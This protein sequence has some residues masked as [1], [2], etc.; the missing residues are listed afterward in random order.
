[1]ETVRQQAFPSLR[2]IRMAGPAGS[3]PKDDARMASQA[4]HYRS[5]HIHSGSDKNEV[6]AVRLTSRTRRQLVR[7]R[8]PPNSLPRP[9]LAKRDSNLLLACRP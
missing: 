3:P 5:Y 9:E 1:M 7:Q 8:L 4:S 6:T 2:R